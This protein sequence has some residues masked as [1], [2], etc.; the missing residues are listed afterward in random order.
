MTNAAQGLVCAGQAGEA[1][2][3]EGAARPGT[4]NQ[5]NSVIFANCIHC[6]AGKHPGIC[7]TIKAIEYH[8]D[9]TVKRVEYKCAADYAAALSTGVPAPIPGNVTYT[10]A[11]QPMSDTHS[12]IIGPDGVVR[13]A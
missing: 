12:F 5:Y 10:G 1:P 11:P 6:G 13:Y 9:G 3:S 4:D 2:A 7:P 8:E